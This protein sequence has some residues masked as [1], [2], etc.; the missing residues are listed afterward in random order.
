MSSAFFW[1]S[2]IMVASACLVSFWAGF[3]VGKAY[4][5]D[6]NANSVTEEK[7]QSMIDASVNAAIAKALG[8]SGK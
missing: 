2:L 1:P 4:Q 5:E 8:V 3:N 6:K 7:V